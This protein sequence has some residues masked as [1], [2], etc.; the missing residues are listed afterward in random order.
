MSRAER[1]AVGRAGLTRAHL[2]E[3][4]TQ[5]VAG[6]FNGTARTVGLSYEGTARQLLA[7]AGGPDRI[8]QWNPAKMV[9]NAASRWADVRRGTKALKAG[10][11]M[12][13]NAV[14]RMEPTDLQTIGAQRM[15]PARLQYLAEQGMR[16]VVHR[17]PVNLGACSCQQ[18]AYEQTRSSSSPEHSR[19]RRSRQ[20]QTQQVPTPQEALLRDRIQQL[21]VEVE[22]LRNQVAQ[23]QAVSKPSCEQQLQVAQ[24]LQPEVAQQQPEAAE[25][26]TGAAQQQPEGAPGSR[27]CAATGC[28]GAGQAVA[29][30]QPEVVQPRAGAQQQPEID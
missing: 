7:D 8:L 15:T 19:P 23:L 25:A 20:Q 6:H 30:R 14:D 11:A 22:A 18:Q 16:R 17:W 24:Q 10:Y 5:H 29:Q 4:A 28:A 21:E 9:R 13:R 12:A 26:Q 3:M 2:A 1:G 27:G